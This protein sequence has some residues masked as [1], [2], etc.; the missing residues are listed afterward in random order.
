[1]RMPGTAASAAAILTFLVAGASAQDQRFA[2]RLG[3]VYLDPTSDNTFQ[4]RKSELESA[5]GAELAV[6]WYMTPR[7]GLEL[8]ATGAADMDVQENNDPI[9]AV[10]VA[11]ITLGLN[12][13]LV[14][15][16]GV[17][18]WV[19]V[20]GGQVVYGDFDLE[21]DNEDIDTE[22][23]TAWGVQTAIDLSPPSWRHVALNLGVKYLK[24]GIDG[25]GDQGKVDVDP[26]IY[27]IL[28]TFRW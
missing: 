10:T 22:N 2:V 24:T 26:L 3:A 5:G 1:M 8:S 19:G 14:R 23:D 17:D 9:G 25:G 18:W 28:L 27:R 4:G 6:E 13:H 21:G 11:P 7:L 15:N 16:R 20:L 12:G